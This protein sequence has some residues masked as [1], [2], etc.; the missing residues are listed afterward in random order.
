M[1]RLETEPVHAEC[2]LVVPAYFHP[3][4]HRMEWDLL[5]AHPDRVRLVILN[6]AGGPGLR[7]DDAHFA[8]LLRLRRAG[9]AIAGYVDTNYGRREPGEALADLERYREWYD[10][11]AVCFDR[12]SVSEE[13]AGHYGQLARVARETGIDSVIFNHGAHPHERYAEHADVLGTFEGD[14]D[15]YRELAVPRWTR[16]HPPERFY[17]VVHSVP[18]WRI[19]EVYLLASVRRARSVYATDRG[20]ANPY[21][22]L[23]V[24]WLD[25][26]E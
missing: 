5:A 19:P 17:H 3:A 15:A 7:P 1:T 12:V 6:C 22:G 9:I 26:L 11:D 8:P 18:P 21:C 4:T 20:G 13:L 2:R 14:W 16:R 24:D 23:S 10:V 25:Y